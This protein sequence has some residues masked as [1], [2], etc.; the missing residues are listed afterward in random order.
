[1]GI[2]VV[3]LLDSVRRE[4][5]G[6]QTFGKAKNE[7]IPLK[8]PEIGILRLTQPQTSNPVVPVLFLDD[9]LKVWA[10]ESRQ[11]GCRWEGKVRK[12]AS[13][14]FLCFGKVFYDP[15]EYKNPR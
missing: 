6:F 11:A 14:P 5:S 13:P 4:I 2:R 10:Q 7:I 3:I 12:V 8:Y 15:P 9:S 1:M